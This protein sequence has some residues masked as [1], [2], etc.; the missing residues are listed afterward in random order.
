M[1]H[2][3]VNGLTGVVMHAK[4]LHRRLDGIKVLLLEDT[5]DLLEL[6]TFVLE[7]EGASV[8]AV[9][10][11]IAALQAFSAER[12][13]VL[14]VDIGLPIYS[15]YVFIDRVRM[16]DVKTPAIALTAYATSTDRD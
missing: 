12:P 14:V 7:Q 6:T 11:V 10:S 4:T 5:R 2:D 3:C 9:D 15:G 1:P 13:D 8:I 16:C